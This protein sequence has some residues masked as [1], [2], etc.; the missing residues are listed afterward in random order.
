MVFQVSEKSAAGADL[1]GSIKY[2]IAICAETESRNLNTPGISGTAA[3]PVSSP[4]G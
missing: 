2:A 3:P 1:F 4:Q